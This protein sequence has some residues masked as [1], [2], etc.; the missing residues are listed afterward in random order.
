MKTR[1]LTMALS[2]VLL[3]SV[4]ACAGNSKAAQGDPIQRLAKGVAEKITVE[5]PILG[6]VWVEENLGLSLAF[7]ED[8]YVNYIQTGPGGT[9]HKFPYIL[10]ADAVVVGVGGN[11]IEYWYYKIDGNNLTLEWLH[12]A[13]LFQR[14]GGNPQNGVQNAARNGDDGLHMFY[15]EDFEPAILARDIVTHALDQIKMTVDKGGTPHAVFIKEKNLMHKWREGDRWS[16]AEMILPA[17]F[18]HKGYER[19]LFMHYQLAL[20]SAGEPCV[21]FYNQWDRQLCIAEKKQGL[22]ETSVI[23]E[24]SF[25]AP[26]TSYQF[27]RPVVAFDKQGTPLILSKQRNVD[28][29]DLRG[30]FLNGRPGPL[31]EVRFEDIDFINESYFLNDIRLTV[32]IT[33]PSR[34]QFGQKVNRG[35]LPGL[36]KDI[37]QPVL[38]V[39]PGGVCH[40]DYFSFERIDDDPSSWYKVKY[41]YST[42]ADGGKT[43]EGPFEVGGD[44]SNYTTSSLVYDTDGTK[45]ISLYDSRSKGYKLTIARVTPDGT[46]TVQKF[47]DREYYSKKWAENSDYAVFVNDNIEELAAVRE[48]TLYFYTSGFNCYVLE[49]GIWHVIRPTNNFNVFDY[50]PEGMLVL[51]DGEIAI[52][53]VN[54]TNETFSFYSNRQ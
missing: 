34:E 30:R 11:K 38:T 1:I 8:G 41:S 13:N 6:G 50:D 45:Y 20:T 40:L 9:K 7:G 28:T 21:V 26:D 15:E 25:D 29:E 37:D 32:E 31:D 17:T 49:D 52:Y 51:E 14:D 23:Q 22:W 3:F 54:D 12:G 48:G 10:Y 33:D 24:R 2:M 42:S 18:L 5:H 39:S 46:M 44:L 53:L 19:N 16:E 43:W 35:V 47:L 36:G 27:D 4:T